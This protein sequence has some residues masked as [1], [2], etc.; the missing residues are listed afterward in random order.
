MF[1]HMLESEIKSM[2]SFKKLCKAKSKTDKS[3]SP[4]SFV[5]ATDI[6]KDKNG[7]LTMKQ[8]E[9]MKQS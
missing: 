5:S 9:K 2:D 7:K 1:I 4:E 6:L 3:C 8:L